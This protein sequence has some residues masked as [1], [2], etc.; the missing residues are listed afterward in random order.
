MAD[1]QSG[2]LKR[3]LLLLI[4]AVDELLPVGQFSQFQRRVQKYGKS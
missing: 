2:L 4:V 3:V 1:D